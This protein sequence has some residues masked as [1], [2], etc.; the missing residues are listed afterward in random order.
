[1]QLVESVQNPL[2]YEQVDKYLLQ[3]SSFIGLDIPE[4]VL[5]SHL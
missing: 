2:K 3:S 5:T 1:M 4:Q